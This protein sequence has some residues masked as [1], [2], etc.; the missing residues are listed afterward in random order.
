MFPRH[1]RDAD[2]LMQRADLA[3]YVAKGGNLGYQIY[4]SKHDRDSR[5]RLALLAELRRAIDENELVLHY[6]PKVSLRTGRVVGVEAL[7][8]WQH[9]SGTL[10]LPEAF[11]PFAEHSGLIG[12]L[13]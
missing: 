7:C 8:R 6:Q 4:A 3:M 1:G 10:I 11:I 2:T 13:P 9:P 12:P 5:N